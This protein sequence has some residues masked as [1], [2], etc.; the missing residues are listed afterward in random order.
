MTNQFN[1][2]VNTFHPYRLVRWLAISSPKIIKFR[3][4]ILRSGTSKM[5][6]ILVEQNYGNNFSAINMEIKP[7]RVPNTS[8]PFWIFLSIVTIDYSSLN[9]IYIKRSISL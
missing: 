5:A 1:P 4:T 3:F 8:P 2:I 7:I 9:L 6:T